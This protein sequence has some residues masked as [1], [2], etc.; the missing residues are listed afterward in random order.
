M[1]RRGPKTP[2]HRPGKEVG[3]RALN[4]QNR[5]GDIQKAGLKLFLE[6]GIASVSI[7]DIAKA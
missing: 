5:I 3:K 1:A 7:D 2:E 6:K 4:R